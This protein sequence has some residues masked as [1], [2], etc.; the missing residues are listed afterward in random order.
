MIVTDASASQNAMKS[1]L[2]TRRIEGAL[3]GTGVI[4]LL[5]CGGIWLYGAVSSR[6]TVREY[7]ANQAIWSDTNSGAVNDPASGSRVDFALWHQKRVK[8][9][10][11]SLLKK[12][13]RPIAILRISK[14]HLEV[15]VYDDTDDLT[16][17]RGVG[18]IRGTAQ[19]EEKG[20]LGIAGHRDGFFRGL[21]DVAPGDD[22]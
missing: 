10:K 9:Y 17:D 6:A 22:N 19:M 3:L 16:L 11:D 7:K 13:D 14:I 5:A 18:R 21:K 1:P 12:M 8:A 2:R 15:P 20:N 4:L